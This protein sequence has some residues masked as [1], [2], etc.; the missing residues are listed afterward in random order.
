MSQLDINEEVENEK[1]KFVLF[2]YILQQGNL[3]AFY[4]SIN[5]LVFIVYPSNKTNNHCFTGWIFED[6]SKR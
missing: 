6:E 4:F 2:N 3:S 1:V 5:F